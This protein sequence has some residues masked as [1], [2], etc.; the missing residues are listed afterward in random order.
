MEAFA[1]A[2][3]FLHRVT[4]ALVKAG[5]STVRGADL[6]VDF[7]ATQG[8]KIIL[9]PPDEGG[10]DPVALEFRLDRDRIDPSPV[11]IVSAHRGSNHK[12]IQKRD[13]K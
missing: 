12:V 13:E 7:G 4:K 5:D 9:D 6:K 1:H 11:H 2:D 8:L 10:P 3:P